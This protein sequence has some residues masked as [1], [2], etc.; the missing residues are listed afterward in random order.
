M[1]EFGPTP[2]CECWYTWSCPRRSLH[3]PHF[4][5]SFCCS[6]WVFFCFLIFQITLFIL[7]FIYSTV[8]PCK[9]FI[10]V[11]V[12]FISKW[13]FYGFY[14]LFCCLSSLYLLFP[15]VH[16]VS[17]NECFNSTSSRLLES[18]LFSSS[19]VLFCSFIWTFFL[20]PHFGSL[21][22]FASVY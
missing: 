17:Y 9:L 22:V 12:F 15:W 13:F 6:D 1:E 4:L 20:S 3:C 10:L 16:W 2:T 21:P 5:D 7:G 18:I 11:S 8:I 19:G 14:V